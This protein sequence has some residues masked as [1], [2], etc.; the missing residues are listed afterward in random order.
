M[1]GMTRTVS[2]R[3]AAFYAIFTDVQPESR[4]ALS[5]LNVRARTAA[6]ATIAHQEK[7]WEQIAAPS[8]GGSLNQSAFEH[9]A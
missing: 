4:W 7:T 2:N 1:C 3:E 9:G 5:R 8:F 6:N